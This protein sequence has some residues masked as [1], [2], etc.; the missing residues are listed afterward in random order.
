LGKK[1]IK[2]LLRL[3]FSAA[4]IFVILRKVDI[5]LAAEHLS[6]ANF[7]FIILALITYSA[8]KILAAYRINSLYQTQGLHISNRLNIKLTFLAMFY[9]LFIPLVGGE[10]Y[11]TYWIN[12]QYKTSVKSLI[13]AALLD[14]GSGLGGLGIVT[15]LVFQFSEFVFPF[16]ELS[17]ALIPLVLMAH[18]LVNRLVF[19]SFLPAWISTTFYSFFI[20]VLQALT[21]YLVVLA[22]GID[23]LQIEYVF[24]FMLASFAY[25]IPIIGARE[26]AFVFGSQQ[27][28][29]DME[30]SLAIG[31]LFYLALAI[32]SL[33]GYWFVLFPNSLNKEVKGE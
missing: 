17:L 9:N 14:R 6:N 12:K 15:I 21:A 7:F 8:S 28:G 20:Q 31:L 18:W 3:L 30:L 13:W 22:L 19:P 25:V 2:L 1:S 5:H 32:S 29:L 11:K 24:V 4:A 23:L 33:S 26:M 16:S 27:L 10:G